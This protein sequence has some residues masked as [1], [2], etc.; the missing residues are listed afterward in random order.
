MTYRRYWKFFGLFI[1]TL[2]LLTGLA[3]SY[4]GEKV[5]TSLLQQ[6]KKEL[7]QEALHTAILI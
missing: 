7:K 6:F 2:A 3:A 5:R 4:I 1:L